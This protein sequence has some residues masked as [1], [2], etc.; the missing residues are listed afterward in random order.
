MDVDI[1]FIKI[2]SINPL[3]LEKKLGNNINLNHT[4]IRQ[5]NIY[6]KFK[7][8]LDVRRHK[9]LTL[10]NKKG[11]L[12]KKTNIILQKYLFLDYK[13]KTKYCVRK[14]YFK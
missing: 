9:I 14:K 3:N 12:N 5:N 10:F 2:N 1:K 11:T 7:E 6:I 8:W 13:I 4:P